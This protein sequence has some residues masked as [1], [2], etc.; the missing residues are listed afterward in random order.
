MKKMSKY[1]TLSLLILVFSFTSISASPATSRTR[2][3][4]SNFEV[5]WTQDAFLPKRTVT[6]LGLRNPQD[7]VF[8]EFDHLF[9]ADRDN[10]RVVVYD[11]VNDE[12]LQIITH[13]LMRAPNGITLSNEGDI[14][15][16]DPLAALVMRFSSEGELI[17]TFE[18]P[19]SIAFSDTSFKPQKISVDNR[20]NMYIISEGVYNGVIQLSNSGEFLGYFTSN[21]VRLSVGQILQDLFFTDAQRALLTRRIPTT[22]TNVFIDDRGV[23]YTTT[24]GTNLHAV[25]KHNTAGQN[26]FD[27][28]YTYGPSDLIDV[29]TDDRGIIYAVSKSGLIFVYSSDGQFIFSFGSS[30]ASFDIAGLFNSISAVEVDSQGQLWILDSEKSFLQSFSPTEYSTQIFSALNY[31]NQGNFSEASNLWGGVLRLNQMSALAHN[32]MGM[33]YMFTEQYDNAMFHFRVAGNRFQYSQAFWEV[34]NE[35]LQANLDLIFLA[36]IIFSFI[37]IVTKKWR[38]KTDWLRPVIDVIHRVTSIKLI[39]DVL[40]VFSFIK[41]PIDSFYDL[42]VGKRGSFKAAMILYTLFFIIY[43]WYLLG[44]G[45]IFQTVTLEDIDMQSVVIGFFSII[46]LTVLCNYLVSSINDGDGSFT[47]IVKLGSYSLAPIMTLYVAIIG[48][49]Y[50]LTI[51]EVF[52]VQLMQQGALVWTGLNLY[53]GIQEVHDYSF[54]EAI[55]SIILT[56]VFILVIALILLII[57]IMAEQVYMFFEAIIREVIRNVAS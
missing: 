56:I 21:R 19:N 14:Y 11:T 3:L 52:I 40:F 47:H 10:A 34:R 46:I 43:I 48:L 37:M 13:P 42:K 12:V 26:L 30:Y 18:R 44:K 7:S 28:Q 24:M 9:I 41:H 6:S 8:N 39:S 20:R 35:W 32:G 17:E 16:A 4:N 22:F 25:K 57:I 2:T 36:I 45:F 15:V 23:V 29:T 5:V 1:L 55:R 54:K 27:N 38:R 31:F 51:N 53:L 50:V 33:S 49:S